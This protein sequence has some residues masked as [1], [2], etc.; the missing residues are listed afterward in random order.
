[1]KTLTVA[2]I[3]S[4]SRFCDVAAN[5]RHFETLIKKASSRGARLVCFPELALSSYTTHPTT[6]EVAQKLPGPLT[7]KLGRIARQNKVY[8]SAGVAEKAGSKYHIAQVVVGPKGYLGKYRKY[9]PTGG[10][11]DC[12]FSRGRS[13]PTFDIDGFKLGI[14]ICFDG[15]HEDTLEAMKRAK[16]DVIHHPHGNGLAL[17]KDAEEWTRAKMTYFVPRAVAARAYILVNNSAGD[18]KYPGGT[19]SYGSGAM[20]IDP[21]GQAIA[22]TTQK[23]RTEK[24]VIAAM[25]KPLSALIPEVEL[26]MMKRKWQ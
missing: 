5:L 20:V 13:F 23:T 8:V 9:H 4:R 26:E 7:D 14:N 3:S 10:E 19:F 11:E 24:M 16:V 1:M 18:M 15:R 25:V 17:G 2:V 12:G 22:R 21:L 6:L